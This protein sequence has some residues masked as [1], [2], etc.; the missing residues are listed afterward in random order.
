ALRESEE[1]F[2]R[3]IA[4]APF[5]ML[6]HAENGEIVVVNQ[7][8]TDITGYTHA[9]I[10]TI[11]AWTERAYGE[12]KAIV[13]EDIDRLYSMQER[14]A[15]GEYVITTRCGEKRTWDFS[16]SPLGQL[17]DGRRLVLSMA[18][19]VTERKQAE[20]AVL[21]SETRY[22]RLFEAA[23][24]GILILDAD[25]G[26]VIDANPFLLDLL[27]YSHAEILG[28]E[29][30]EIGVFHDIVAS[31]AA[32]LELQETG[33]I[34][35]EHLPLETKDGR[36]IEVEFVSNIYE[37][38]STQVI[39]C[40]IRDITDR[41]QAQEALQASEEKYRNIVE[42]AQEGI[43]II[44]AENRTTF[45][46]QRM[47][48][49]L[50]YTVDEMLGRSLFAFMDDEG[51][52]QAEANV[53]RRR[54]GIPEQHEFVFRC[55][56]GSPLWAFLST[57][58]IFDQQ[59][60][61]CGA[62]ALVTDITDL[63]RT[64]QAEREQRLLAEALAQTCNALISSLSLDTLMNTILENVSRVVPNDAA[65]IMLIENDLARIAYWRG[66]RSERIPFLQNLRLQVSQ[67]SNLH[68]M[69]VTQQPF[70]AS[71]IDHFTDWL[72]NLHTEWVK[73]YVAAP[74]R[75]HGNVIGFLNV[76]SGTPG[77]YTETH[78]QHLQAFADQASVAIEHTQ[79]YE[80]IQRHVNELEQ[81][82]I[83]RTAQLNHAKERVEA[84]LNSGNDVMILCR[85]D[86]RIDQ[87][88]PAFEAIFQC[89]PDEVY[90]Q[91]IT[92]LA[93]PDHTA[94]LEQVFAD[95]IENQHPRRFE[96]TVQC[97]HRTNF[98]ADIVLSPIVGQDK[99]LMGVV[100]SL[101]DM[102]EHKQLQER[103]RQMLEHEMELSELKTRYVSMA[104]HD[105]R[106]PLA[107][108]RSAIDLMQQYGDRLTNEQKRTKYDHVQAS[109]NVMVSLLDDILT[110]GQV[111]SGKLVFNPELLD[112][113]TF[114]QDIV[115]ERTQAP[116]DAS[117]IVF[118]SR[119]DCSH[120]LMDAKLLRHILGNLLSNAIKYSPEDRPVTFTLHCEPDQITFC[121]QDQ[122]IGIPE[123]DQRRL[124]ETFHRASNARQISGTGL[125]LAI[126]KQ[127]VELHGG[128]ITFE[129]EEGRG[130]T[131]T[132]TLPVFRREGDG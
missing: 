42:T 29:L 57:N 92:R 1:R 99:M 75:S 59:G 56:D 82:V 89:E 87:V 54:Q 84:I 17:S 22:R 69:L 2:R 9:D 86:G 130:T 94:K 24:D 78:A 66:Y 33:Y 62:Q 91:P 5:P 128:T 77:F 16:S 7:T 40:N 83:E 12:R 41:K 74:I 58:P 27:G 18:M 37:A 49:M 113:V 103:L 63:K 51:K 131:F 28:K 76:D 25:T 26:K 44:D 36:S 70:L 45:V 21:A 31:Q 65:N 14:Q 39:Q 11:D 105:L 95:V 68:H 19:D 81:R 50:G 23:K 96:I 109:I 100:C 48:E 71:Y 119:G 123:D 110:I 46:N 88:N 129:S 101:R 13:Q 93:V 53:E 90:G 132:V 104:A 47:A 72:H 106:N 85:T 124:F 34:R 32:F 120:A 117:H 60:Q 114:C 115:A 20:Q 73:S 35:Y 30:W 10:P 80:Q 61:Y 8:W 43:W 67:T 52:A 3:A 79:L 125:G 6:I 118:S 112:V 122:G 15:E 126:V 121:V 108:I 116:G 38:N 111:E 97:P 4:D 55:K 107:V 102:T 64:Q 127:S 98:D